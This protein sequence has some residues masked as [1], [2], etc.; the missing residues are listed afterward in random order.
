MLTAQMLLLKAF[1]VN[2]VFLMHCDSICGVERV[3]RRMGVW[4][5]RNLVTHTVLHEKMLLLAFQITYV[6]Y[7]ICLIYN[8]AMP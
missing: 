3:A 5:H 1:A 8:S 7:V 2:K 6:L 4:S